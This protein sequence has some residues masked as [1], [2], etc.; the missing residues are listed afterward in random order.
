VEPH[1]KTVARTLRV[2]ADDLGLSESINDGIFEAYDLGIVTHASV[3]AGGPAFEHAVAGLRHRPGLRAG[4]HV[5]L[6]ELPPLSAGFR[7]SRF[8]DG[9]RFASI[10]ETAAASVCGEIRAEELDREVEAQIGRIRDAGIEIG[11]LDGHQHVH[12]LP[13][14]AAAA[15]RACR[16]HAIPAIRVPIESGVPPRVPLAPAARAATLA[17][18]SAPLG[19][20]ALWS[21]VST[22][23]AFHG[24][25]CSG[26][27]SLERFAHI[28]S[29][30]RPG[31]NDLMCHPGRGGADGPLYRLNWEEELRA[32][33]SPELRALVTRLG[34]KLER[35]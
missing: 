25:W 5:S 32:L 10:F 8:F 6:S 19:V 13:H 7:Q 18:A 21:G 28:I 9:R 15:V 34:V 22:T 14:V 4:V 33:T 23:G 3:L 30:L 12:V 20:M 2:T 1:A 29:H 11:H 17:L 26:R 24:A 16:K 31:R 35:D 27:G